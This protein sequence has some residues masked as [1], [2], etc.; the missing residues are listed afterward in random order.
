VTVRFQDAA[1]SDGAVWTGS[2]PAFTCVT[3]NAKAKVVSTAA[4]MR[5]GE[6]MAYH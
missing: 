4:R 1:R 2:V 5:L 3:A 6:A